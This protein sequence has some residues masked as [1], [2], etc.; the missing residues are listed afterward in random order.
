MTGVRVNRD[1]ALTL[2]DADGS[3]ATTGATPIDAAVSN[4]DRFLYVLTA[5]D[6]S[7]SQ[8]RIAADGSL[9]SLGAI[10]GLAASSVGLVAR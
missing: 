8:Y 4:D 6:Q 7:I 10:G 1:G 5:G 3:S 9:T 2:L